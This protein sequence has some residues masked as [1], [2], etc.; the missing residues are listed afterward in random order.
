MIHNEYEQTEVQQAHPQAQQ[1]AQ[2]ADDPAHVRRRAEQHR[3]NGL[4]PELDDLS[5]I[6]LHEIKQPLTASMNLLEAAIR[7]AQNNQDAGNDN[8]VELMK[9]ANDQLHRAVDL[10]RTL[11]NDGSNGGAVR[12]ACDLNEVIEQALHIV[13]ER[14]DAG[15]VRLDCVPGNACVS[16]RADRTKLTQAMVNVL[17]NA[18]DASQRE[19]VRMP[20]V[21]VRVDARQDVGVVE[22]HNEGPPLSDH[23]RERLFDPFFTTKH[24]GTGLGL[25]ISRRVFEQHGGGMRLY[26]A[27]GGGVTCEMVLPIEK[28]C[29][30]V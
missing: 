30:D 16:V 17:Q 11:R 7:H 10:L 9:S 2:A 28:E 12:E 23:A 1:D 26:N 18:I 3:S 27:D 6:L 25:A 24:Q 19:G 15:R 29:G 13:R 4:A 14:V 22:I 5:V 20:V 8:V 21:T